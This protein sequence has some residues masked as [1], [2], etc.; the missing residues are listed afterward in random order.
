MF[1]GTDKEKSDMKA[2]ADEKP[3]RRRQTPSL[4]SQGLR[5]TGNMETEGEIQVD[6]VLEG[7]LK[8]GTL[9]VGETA[10]VTGEII[11][12][13]CIIRGRVTGRI[14]ARSVLLTKTARVIGDIWHQ[15][16]AMEAGAFLEGHCKRIEFPPD[17]SKETAKIAA[18]TSPSLPPKTAAAV[19]LVTKDI[20]K[21]Q[22]K[23][24]DKLVTKKAVQY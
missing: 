12:D 24:A 9:T 7:D 17:P 4:I 3:L 20:N 19:P 21:P 11:A 2:K 8:T 10:T 15:D 13:E 18:P 1:F 16:L 23:P 6:G 14:R 5:I 22:P